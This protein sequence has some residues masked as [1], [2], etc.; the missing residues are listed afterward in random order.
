M[1]GDI[2][3]DFDKD[4]SGD[5]FLFRYSIQTRKYQLYYKDKIVNNISGDPNNFRDLCI[6]DK[7]EIICTIKSHKLLSVK[8]NSLDPEL[9]KLRRKLN[10]SSN[11]VIFIGKLKTF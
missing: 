3:H 9:A 5:K 2:L 1:Y 4:N 8:K 10:E 6:T 11:P 7:N